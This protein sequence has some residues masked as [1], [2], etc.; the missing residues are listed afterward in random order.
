[1]AIILIPTPPQG[2]S[3]FDI[4]WMVILKYLKPTQ[5][6]FLVRC[7]GIC[8]FKNL[9]ILLGASLKLSSGVLGYLEKLT[10]TIIDE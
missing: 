3:T 10:I 5:N 2:K 1:M 7:Y 4:A 8:S 6:P 9:I